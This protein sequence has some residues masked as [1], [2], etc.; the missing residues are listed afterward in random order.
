MRSR[1]GS[2]EL[3]PAVDEMIRGLNRLHCAS[4]RGQRGEQ[5]AFPASLRS[6]TCYAQALPDL[7]LLPGGIMRVAPLLLSMTIV[8]VVQNAPPDPPR[9]ISSRAVAGPCDRRLIPAEA[10]S[11]FPRE[12]CP[13]RT[14]LFAFHRRKERYGPPGR[15]FDLA[16]TARMPL[17]SSRYRANDLSQVSSRHTRR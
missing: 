5:R 9:Q 4:F 16:A 8:T 10:Q 17:A 2:P 7:P 6:I 15:T 11:S 14:A 3:A 1:A 13:I 12:G